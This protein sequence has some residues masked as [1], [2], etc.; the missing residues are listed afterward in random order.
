MFKRLIYIALAIL[1]CCISVVTIKVLFFLNHTPSI[2]QIATEIEVPIP[3]T[4]TDIK[5]HKQLVFNKIVCVRFR[6]SPSDFKVLTS[7]VAWINHEPLLSTSESTDMAVLMR[8]FCDATWWE[9]ENHAD[10]A[11]YK[12]ERV[13]VSPKRRKSIYFASDYGRLNAAATD[14]V[15]VHIVYFNEPSGGGRVNGTGTD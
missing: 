4:A 7:E 15:T 3:A 6:I 10:G 14:A 12:C 11:C 1:V 8:H 9:P 2:S 13:R 5:Y